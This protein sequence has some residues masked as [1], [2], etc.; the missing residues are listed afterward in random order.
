MATVFDLDGLRR[1]IQELEAE[2]RQEKFWKNA[3]RAQK[4]LTQLEHL[5]KNAES[6]GKLETE[7][8]NFL[9]VEEIARNDKRIEKELA[10]QLEGAEKKIAEL[11]FQLL[12]QSEY[13]SR[14]A[15]LSVHSGTG[16][17]DAQDW[18]QML[19]RM[20][21]RFAEKKD[22]RSKILSE[23]RGQE[24]GIKSSTVEIEGPYA[25]GHL[26]A[27]VG[28]HRLVRLSPFNANN[29]RQTSFALVEVLPEIETVSEIKIPPSDLR[30]DTFRSG[31]AGGQSVNKT[32]SAVRVTHIP[33]GLVAACQNERSQAQNKEQ[34][35][36]ILQAKLLLREIE[37]RE[38][39]K[40]ALKGQ[41]VSVQ[42][43]SQIRSYVLH[44]YKLVKDHRTKVESK[45]PEEVLDGNLEPF[46]EA[47]LKKFCSV[48]K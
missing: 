4:I 26:K 22:W 13:D 38:H 11:E 39:E 31:G 20:Y 21:L 36:K 44:P 5:K 28:I 17:V 32:S 7:V 12:F 3:E 15:I 1:K 37:D 46:I 2:T 29:L 9:E 16:G 45:N 33:T 35:L 18:T 41:H 30:T 14:S 34:A 40:K 25:Y 47:Y 8:D 24:A 42:W 48:K 10:S 27:E 43:G 19:L 23:T 6:L